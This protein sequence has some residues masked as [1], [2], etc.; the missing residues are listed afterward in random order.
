MR[1]RTQSSSRGVQRGVRLLCRPPYRQLLSMRRTYPPTPGTANRPVGLG[2]RHAQPP[3]PHNL[4]TPP[5]ARTPYLLH[6]G[7]LLEHGAGAPLV[8]RPQVAVG[9]RRPARRG[10][11]ARH[12]QPPA[13]RAR[14]RALR[15]AQ[16]P[17]PLALAPLLLQLLP[18]RCCGAQHGPDLGCACGRLRQRQLGRQLLARGQAPQQHAERVG[19]GGQVA[20]RWRGRWRRKAHSSRHD[21]TQ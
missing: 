13:A 20:G 6:G 16:P 17:Q 10:Q 19:C 11:Q 8:Q 18:A 3:P 15:V 21:G 14:A 2:A 1:A 9:T 7:P 12:L 5:P 4:R